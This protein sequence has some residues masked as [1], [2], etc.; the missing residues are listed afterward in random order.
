MDRYFD[1]RFADTGLSGSFRNTETHEVRI[2]NGGGLFDWQG[3]E[4]SLHIQLGEMGIFETF[5][6]QQV[7]HI[8]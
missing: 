6:D 1:V 5:L 7:I 3:I 4:Q 2:A 8:L